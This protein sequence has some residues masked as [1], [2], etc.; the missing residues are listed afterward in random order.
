MKIIVACFLKMV[1]TIFLVYAIAMIRNGLADN[2]VYVATLLALAGAY[3]ASTAGFWLLLIQ[4]MS[5]R[6]AHWYP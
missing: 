6:N 5:D 2:D 1:A 4:H 3:A